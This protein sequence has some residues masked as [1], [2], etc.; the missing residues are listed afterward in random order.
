MEIVDVVD[1]VSDTTVR[2]LGRVVTDALLT[3]DAV[4]EV[5]GMLLL[6]LLLLLLRVV[7][8]GIVN[9]YYSCR[10]AIFVESCY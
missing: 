4:G 3:E 7:V 2:P 8:V 6:L 9:D 10:N 1:A 5:A